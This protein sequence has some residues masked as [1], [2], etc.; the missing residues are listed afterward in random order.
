MKKLFSKLKRRSGATLNPRVRIAPPSEPQ[1][2]TKSNST[3]AA[4]LTKLGLAERL[5]AY[6]LQHAQVFFYS[7]GQL[8]RSPLATLMTAAVIGIAL[9]LPIGLQVVLQNVQTLD[10]DWESGGDISLF[11]KQEVN[12]EEAQRLAEQVRK[13]P[14]VDSVT[15]LSR[16]QALQEFRALSGFGDAL[17]ALHENPLPA[18]VVVHPAH[19]VDPDRISATE[20]LVNELRGLPQVEIAQFDM[21]W[22]ERLRAML[23]IAERT[24][25]VLGSLL[26]L[27]V[28]LIIG[29][30]IRLTIQSRRD[31][32]EIIKLIGATDAFIRRP[33]LYSGLWYGFLGAIIAWLLVT[34]S[35]TL[36]QGP[37][38]RLAALYNSH[39]K[40]SGLDGSTS[41]LLVCVAVVLGLLGSLIAVKRHLAAIEPV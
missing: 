15:S 2:K 10:A 34:L 39:F 1:T 29:N 33:F 18:V 8:W 21:Q 32:I 7:L 14:G 22:L 28:L 6:A 11:L 36:L 19:A 27:A 38:G 5:R 13:L 17:D 31:E 37:V 24:V 4:Q 12:D 16:T 41:L 20:Q 9:A 26:A 3:S 40:L 30:T 25:W 23:A 35:L